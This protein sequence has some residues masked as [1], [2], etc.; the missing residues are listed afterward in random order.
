MEVKEKDVR[1]GRRKNGMKM[2]NVSVIR[3]ERK[4]REKK[5]EQEGKDE[6]KTERNKK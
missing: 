4:D 2:E 3:E 1:R 6:K 5:K